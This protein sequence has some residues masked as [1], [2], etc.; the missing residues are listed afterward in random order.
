[1]KLFKR[2]KPISDL[3]AH[4]AE[5]LKTLKEEHNPLIITQNGEEKPSCKT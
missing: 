1:M 4:A 2:I 5:V 3:K